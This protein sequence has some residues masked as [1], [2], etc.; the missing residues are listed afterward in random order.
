MT[1]PAKLNEYNHAEE[2]ARQLLER[3]GW[4]YAPREALAVEQGGE[5]EVLLKGRLRAALL[6]LNEWLTEA[7][8]DPG[9]LRVGERQRHRH[10]PQPGGPR[11]PDLRDASDRGR[12]P[13]QGH[14]HRPVLRLR[15]SRK[16]P[17]RVR[18]HHP[19]P[20][21][22]GQR[23]ERDR[24]RREAGHTPTWCSSSTASPWW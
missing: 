3:L 18:G 6:R 20:G 22:A 16:R 21:P 2:P 13:G 15:P 7:Q 24:G 5:R 8:A 19:V 12:A 1:T 10:G 14:P 9:H 4:T 17:Q 11:V 23:T